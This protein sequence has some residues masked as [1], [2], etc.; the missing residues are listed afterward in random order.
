MSLVRKVTS[1]ST[2]SERFT[3]VVG[4]GNGDGVTGIGVAGII[5]SSIVGVVKGEEQ[6]RVA[7]AVSSG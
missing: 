3:T 5:F 2:S 6:V 1:E 7:G 4:G